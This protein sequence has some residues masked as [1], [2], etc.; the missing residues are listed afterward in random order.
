MNIGIAIQIGIMP[1]QYIQPGLF[2]IVDIIYLLHI[3]LVSNPSVPKMRIRIWISFAFNNGLTNQYQ[4]TF[5]AIRQIGK[6]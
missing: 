2:G 3:F 4:L 1:Y 5:H 6:Y